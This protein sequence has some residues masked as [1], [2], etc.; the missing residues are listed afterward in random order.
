MNSLAK[1]LAYHPL[2]QELNV[3]DASAITVHRRILR[4]KKLMRLV[5]EH[6]YAELA[7][8]LEPTQSLEGL[9]IVELGCGAG[10]LEQ[11]IPGVVKTDCVANSNAERVINAEEMP[12]EDN[13]VRLFLMTGAM[14]HMHEPVRFLRE[15]ERCL[16]PGGRVVMVEPTAS[17]VGRL[18]TKLLHPYEFYDVK[19]QGWKNSGEGRMKN[20]NC[21]LPW[22]ILV[23]DRAQYEA[24]F[25]RLQIREKRAHT[26]LAYYITGGMTYRSLVPAA[27]AAPYMA[28][29][30]CMWPLLPGLCTLMTVQLEKA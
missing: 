28:L 16:A 24:E 27:L 30:K 15:A 21:A 19:A 11:I 9:P 23:R 4:G 18:L 7:R 12:F 1:K 3:D 14:H 5:Y 20:A 26:L 6:W 8:G 2:A 29:E 17:P 25:P 10:F 13:S 22:I